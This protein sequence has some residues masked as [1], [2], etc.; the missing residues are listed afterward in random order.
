MIPR[1]EVGLI[2]ATL[3]LNQH[4]FGQDVYAALLLVML[5]T[6]VG[7][8]PALRWRL[9]AL[10]ARRNRDAVREASSG[11]IALV[12]VDERGLVDLDVEPLPERRARRRAPRRA[13][14]RR[15]IPRARRCSSGSKCSRPGRAGG[16][17]RRA[18]SS[19]RCCAARSRARGGC[20]PRPGCCSDACPS[21]TMRWSAGGRRRS[22]STRLRHCDSRGCRESTSS[23]RSKTTRR[24]RPPC[25]WP[26]SHST[27]AKTPRPSG[28][29]RAR[30]P[31]SGS[32]SVHE[33][34]SRSPSSS[35][36]STCCAPRRMRSDAL[37]E[38]SVLQIAVHLDSIEQADAL[39]LL[40]RAVTTL[41]ESKSI[42]CARCTTWCEP[43]SRIRNW[44]DEK[45]ATRSRRGEP[46]RHGT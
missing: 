42:S 10:R 39:Y 8:P 20:S 36:T 35:T 25:C 15:V 2:F 7:T 37:S 1:G 26:R 5:V 45:P 6:T 46:R 28:R 9:L 38:E 34:S 21:S 14:V 19:S 27:R 40:S 16:T 3:G 43:P 33:S 12:H 44:S 29:R 18:P 23:S 4:V 32:I 24:T 31:C 22:S 11:G 30:E 13:A 17:T 41:A